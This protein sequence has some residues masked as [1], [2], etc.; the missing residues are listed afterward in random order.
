VV[1][2]ALASTMSSPIAT[3]SLP[4]KKE[5]YDATSCHATSCVTVLNDGIIVGGSRNWNG[6]FVP[7]EPAGN[8]SEML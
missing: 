8:G 5:P 4:E 6:T 3:S 2:A 1:A 7:A